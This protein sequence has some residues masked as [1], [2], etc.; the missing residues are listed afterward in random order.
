MKNNILKSNYNYKET[1]VNINN[2]TIKPTNK[3]TKIPTET[4]TEKPTLNPTSII[5]TKV[6]EIMDKLEVLQE[7]IKIIDDEQMYR[8]YK[9]YFNYLYYTLT[10]Y[11][12]YLSY[13][14]NGNKIQ[15]DSFFYSLFFGP[16]YIIYKF[17]TDY[18]RCF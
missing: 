13:K 15:V 6:P 8:K 4:P 16:F 12:I 3:V 2:Q 5:Q 17:T 11:A 18:R 14:C 1:F 9:E 7:K 10:L